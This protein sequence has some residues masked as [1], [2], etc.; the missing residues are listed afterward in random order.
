MNG[1]LWVCLVGKMIGGYLCVRKDYIKDIND[2]LSVNETG[3]PQTGTGIL[4]NETGTS[5]LQD[6]GA[7]PRLELKP[8]ELVH[9]TRENQKKPTKYLMWT[10][11]TARIIRQI[12]R[13]ELK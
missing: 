5:R 11:A 3:V 2:M 13:L 4:G 9:P 12:P 6:D 8:A 1:Y 10:V 7:F